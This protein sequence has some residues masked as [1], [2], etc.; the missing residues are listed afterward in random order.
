MQG[1]W[2]QIR[3]SRAHPALEAGLMRAIHEGSVRETESTSSCQPASKVILRPYSGKPA[4]DC[5]VEACQLARANVQR[6]LHTAQWADSTV[7]ALKCRNC[8]QEEHFARSRFCHECGEPLRTQPDEPSIDLTQAL[9][10]Q[11]DESAWLEAESK[12]QEWLA[13]CGQVE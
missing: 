9:A 3:A 8:G 12:D 13:R 2:Q 5:D 6:A 1:R 10:E 11:M 4:G 7:A